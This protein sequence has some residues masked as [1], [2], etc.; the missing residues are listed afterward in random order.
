MQK[1]KESILLEF[2][3]CT[4]DEM[5]LHKD[6]YVNNGYISHDFAQPEIVNRDDFEHRHV[7]NSIAKDKRLLIVKRLKKPECK[8]DKIKYEAKELVNKILDYYDVSKR[9]IFKRCRKEEVRSIRQILQAMVYFCVQRNIILE[10]LSLAKIGEIT[11][12]MNHATVLNSIKRVRDHY[13]VEQDYR[14]RLDRLMD[15]LKISEKLKC[16]F[17]GR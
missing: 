7:I 17:D 12:H 5:E 8:N 9:S 16:M 13:E 14:E 6:K 15:H 10:N 1:L 11:G 4:K 3:I 2:H